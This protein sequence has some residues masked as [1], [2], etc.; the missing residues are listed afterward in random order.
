M[1]KNNF[2]FKCNYQAEISEIEK[3]ETALRE[4]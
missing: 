1:R 3:M 2:L 4:Y